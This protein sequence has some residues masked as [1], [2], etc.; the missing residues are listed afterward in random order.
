MICARNEIIAKRYYYLTEMK[1]M[2]HDD[3][4]HQLSQ[5]EFFLSE[6][7]ILAI[8]R[9]MARE[10]PDAFSIQEERMSVFQKV[11]ARNSQKY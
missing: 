10:K 2:R 7:T 9:R 3:A 1:R 4:M 6:S 8:L 11:C 5:Q